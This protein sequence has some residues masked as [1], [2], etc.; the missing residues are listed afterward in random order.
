MDE[1]DWEPSEYELTRGDLLKRAGVAATVLALPGLHAAQAAGAPLAE[2]PSPEALYKRIKSKKILVAN[3]GGTTQKAREV[4]FFDA[5]TRKTGV[6][7]VSVDA[8][9]ALGDRQMEGRAKPTYDAFHSAADAIYAYLKFG[10]LPKLPAAA[11]RN[12][13]MEPG[14]RDYG[15][16]TFYVGHVQA[17]LPG[18]FKNA[19]PRTWKDF[20]N[21]AKFP[22]KR[23][24]PGP[25]FWDATAEAALL[26]D[27]VAPD[28]LYPLDLERAHAKLNTIRDHL[29]FYNE[30]PQVQQFLTSRSVAIAFAPNG[31][32]AA[33]KRLG[34]EI[35]IVYNQAI[36][37]PNCFTT[38][39]K[40]P[41]ADAAYALADW[42]TDARRQSIFSILTN[43]GPGNKAA[44]RYLDRE[45]LRELPN[46][47][48]NNFVKSNN[49]ILARQ[50][51]AYVKANEKF[52]SG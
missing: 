29:I 2:R 17:Y 24:W 4:A 25:G 9:P 23:A 12:D 33:L 28:K 34:V 35:N 19:K 27:G 16:Q 22:G 11:R 40:A 15:W 26:A 44:F 50:F 14:A 37:K 7:I 39:P 8:N 3:Y 38:P 6:E 31:L 46:S 5:F 21:V 51:D 41:H 32:F 42:C 10:K 49:K 1:R 36:V 52:F 47:P 30:F 13:L 45:T 18:T 20:F 43:Y 48:A